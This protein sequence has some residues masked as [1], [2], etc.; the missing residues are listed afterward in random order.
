[1][2]VGSTTGLPPGNRP[3]H[4]AVGQAD[5]VT[6]EPGDRLTKPPHATIPSAPVSTGRRGRQDAKEVGYLW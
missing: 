6:C 3:A 4:P 2:A 5:R 1:M